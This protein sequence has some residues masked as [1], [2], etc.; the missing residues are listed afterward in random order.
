MS[1]GRG[2]INNEA[3]LIA[4]RGRAAGRSLRSKRTRLLIADAPSK[5][6]RS[7]GAGPAARN[8]DMG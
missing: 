1:D 7:T 4:S 5:D 6:D 8:R 3:G 2:D